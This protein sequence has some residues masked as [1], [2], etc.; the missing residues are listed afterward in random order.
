[1]KIGYLHY[2][3]NYLYGKS[4]ASV[5]VY[6]YID[7][8]REIGHE[9]EIMRHGRLE[10]NR[11]FSIPVRTKRY[12]DWL[13]KWLHEPR[14]ILENTSFFSEQSWMSK[15]KLDAVIVRY[16]FGRASGGWAA[17]QTKTPWV[18][19]VDAP[20][21]LES[22]HLTYY[23][24]IP[25]L[26]PAIEKWLIGSC[27]AMVLVARET[28]DYYLERGVSP[29]KMLLVPNGVDTKR[30]HP[31]IDRGP[32]RRQWGLEGKLVLGFVGGFYPWHGME[33]LIYLMKELL[34]RFPEL[35]VLM[36][37][38]GPER[39]RLE[40]AAHEFQSSG[41]VIFTGAR[42]RS[43]IPQYLASIDIALAPAPPIK[44]YYYSPMKLFEY[45]A[46]GRPLVAAAIGQMGEIVQE[47]GNG[48]LFE[49][50]DWQS[51]AKQVERLIL[52]PGLRKRCAQAA[53]QSVLGTYTWQKAA[54]RVCRLL[55]EIRN[56][57]RRPAEGI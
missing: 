43:E 57:N 6:E 26:C 9:V 47:G 17:K 2:L 10:E 27:D 36:V 8:W 15:R 19:Q 18:L 29:S 16:S 25:G 53:R 28:Y 40:R 3:S 11:P 55:E 30:F 49:P 54:E 42:E 35:T 34:P 24:R 52:D 4:G 56:G 1:M 21:A 31:D 38:D 13:A 39:E 46:S 14:N 45:M 20:F 12:P 22:P 48:L 44:K 23:W 5:H 41:R 7:A 33:G 50:G 51:F 37:G 32:V